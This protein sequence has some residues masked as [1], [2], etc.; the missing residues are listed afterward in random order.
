MAFAVGRGA[1]KAESMLPWQNCNSHVCC[2]IQRS[3]LKRVQIALTTFCAERPFLPNINEAW[4][5]SS[6]IR[7]G[8]LHCGSE[9]ADAFVRTLSCDLGHAAS[10]RLISGLGLHFGNQTELRKKNE[11]ETGIIIYRG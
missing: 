3:G 9:G 2:G 11:V 7:S 10:T 4:R 6:E 5:A 1:T 8:M